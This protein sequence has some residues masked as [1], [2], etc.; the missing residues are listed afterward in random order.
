MTSDIDK[1]RA[2]VDKFRDFSR[3]HGLDFKQRDTLVM[4]I[5]RA[6]DKVAALEAELAA[7]RAAKEAAERELSLIDAVMARRP[8]L[9]QPTRWQN[10]EKAITTAA[11]ADAAI[12][13]RDEALAE[14]D[15]EKAMHA[16][17]RKRAEECEKATLAEYE[18][19][20]DEAIPQML[21]AVKNREILAAQARLREVGMVTQQELDQALRER[22]EYRQARDI[23]A[24]V[25]EAACT[26]AERINAEAEQYR[27]E[28]DEARQRAERAERIISREERISDSEMMALLRRVNKDFEAEIGEFNEHLSMLASTLACGMPGKKTPDQWCRLISDGIDMLTRPLLERAERAEADAAVMRK[29]IGE[30]PAHPRVHDVDYDRITVDVIWGVVIRCIEAAKANAGQPL[31]DELARLREACEEVYY[32]STCGGDMCKILRAALR[33][34]PT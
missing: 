2:A 32:S 17:W 34:E 27:R 20:M 11:R 12:R 3:E 19:S 1:A 8:A 18:K 21:D 4:D 13:E 30:L 33:K 24:G 16:A 29:A 22:D 23:A 25:A 31:L 6:L 15:T 14:L 5:H 28:R 9:D 10:V 7:E 26:T